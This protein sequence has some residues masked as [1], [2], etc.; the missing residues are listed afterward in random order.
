[1]LSVY[2]RHIMMSTYQRSSS[3]AVGAAAASGN[4]AA[5]LASPGC[6]SLLLMPSGRLRLWAGAVFENEVGGLL[7]HH[8]RRCVG[9]AGREVRKDRRIDHPQA[10]DA[11]H[12]QPRIDRRGAR[13]RA[14]G[15][16]A[17]GVEHR[18]RALA[19]IGEHRPL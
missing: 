18:A 8:D 13:V 19:E 5:S 6:S 11:V 1:M 9:V 14:H 7:G 2:T 17:T 15:A 16:R 10:A 3:V 12:A 4:A